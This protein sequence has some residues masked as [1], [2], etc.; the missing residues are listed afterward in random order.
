MKKIIFILGGARSGKSALA[1]KK[2]S[3]LRGKKAFIATL[4]PLDGEMKARVAEHKK[5]RG[6]EWDSF[7]EPLD[8]P[9]LLSR[10]KRQCNVV[11]LDCL[12]LWLTNL[13]MEK[14]DIEEATGKLIS[15]LK[16]LRGAGVSVFVVSNEVGTGI[17]P[18]NKMARRFR[19]LAGRLNAQMAELADE[20]YLCVAGLPLK[21]KNPRRLNHPK[22][23]RKK[24][25]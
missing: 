21:I 17:V 5:Q 15:A 2:A 23:K 14:S 22:E 19:D 25:T 4:R 3:R 7:E 13:V 11:V 16:D 10:L 8:V 24:E 6:P 20:A 12:T 18:A 9:G 1:L